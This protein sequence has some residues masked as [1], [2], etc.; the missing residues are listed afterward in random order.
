MGKFHA[1]GMDGLLHSIGQLPACLAAGRRRDGGYTWRQ[2]V[3]D[4]PLN[5]SGGL[6][7]VDRLAVDSAGL[8]AGAARSVDIA[9][10]L[11]G[12]TAAGSGGQP[13]HTGVAAL[14]AAMASV[15]TRQS[16]RV[17]GQGDDLHTASALYTHTDGDAAD[18]VTRSI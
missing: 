16:T 8:S 15:R 4:W 9:Q 11:A 7:V 12:G 14:D 2:V 5:G 3:A 13:S 10:A 18:G 6:R 17:S 1:L